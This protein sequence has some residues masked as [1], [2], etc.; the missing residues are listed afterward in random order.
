[1][2]DELLA[3][4]DIE[5]RYDDKPVVRALSLRVSAGEIVCLLGPSGCG[6]TTVLRAIAGFQPLT[7]GE[8]LIGGQCMSRRGF[9]LPPEKRRVGVVFQDYALFPHL[10]VED[11]VAFGLRVASRAER[12]RVA[13]DILGIVG[14]MGLEA[15]Y[16]HELSGGQQ[17]RVAIARALAPRPDLIL[18]DEPFS[19]LDI[20]LR[21]RLS[22]ELRDILKRQGMTA[23]LVTHD[24][25][26][27]F[28]LGDQVGVMHDGR[29]VQWDTPYNLYHQPCCRFVADFIGQGVFLRGTLLS[30]DTIETEIGIYRGHR[31]YQWAKGTPVDVLLR[32]D[33]IVPDPE[34]A[35][36]AVVLARAFKGAEILYTLR[37]PSG[38]RLLALFPSHADHALGSLVGIRVE[39]TH[40]VAFP[41]AQAAAAAG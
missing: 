34:G 7:A 38:G 1:M 14:L 37:L 26:E 36:R 12:L 4:N 5:C 11:N 20:E 15:R 30:P 29:I 9:T 40:L 41:A 27:A 18:L 19:N 21:E 23:I 35:L 8:L 10:T 33:D 39:A 2:A 32:P 6:K 3:L 22:D 13:H 31:P 24:Q 28:A 17:Q 25:H 16:P